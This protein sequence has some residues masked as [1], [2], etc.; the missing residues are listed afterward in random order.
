MVIVSFNA[1]D[2]LLQQQNAVFT[3]HIAYTNEAVARLT[4]IAVRNVE[5]FAAGKPT[6]CCE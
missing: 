2:P 3:P 5:A 6:T 1:K 4:E